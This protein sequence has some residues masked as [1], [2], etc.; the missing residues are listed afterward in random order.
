MRIRTRWAC[1]GHAS[2]QQAWPYIETADH[3]LHG[4]DVCEPALLDE[5]KTF[6]P[7]T[8]VLGNCDPWSVKDWGATETAEVELDGIKIAMIHDAGPRDGRRNRMRKRFPKAR[9]DVR[10]FAHPV[11][12][13]RGRT[14]A[15][16]PG[17]PD[18]ETP[19]PVPV[20]G[21]PLDRQRRCR[22]RDLPGVTR[23]GLV[24][25]L[26]FEPEEG[27]LDLLDRGEEVGRLPDAVER[28]EAA[29]LDDRIAERAAGLF[30][31]L[32]STE[33][34]RTESNI[35][36]PGLR[37]APPATHP[38]VDLVLVL[39]HGRPDGVGGQGRVALS[40]RNEGVQ[41][42]EGLLMAGV[43]STSGSIP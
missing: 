41:A 7:V 27:V 28:G 40:H 10:P 6:A 3:I 32:P 23:R 13:R 11:E 21:H 34:P 18:V 8:V 22:R 37:R 14:L 29:Q 33:I 15:L 17:Q 1:R 26:A 38:F 19:R 16:Q 4:G 30:Q 36:W 43:Q 42:V 9:G 24:G 39:D 35:V 12:R 2:A 5:L 25:F 20:H 31:K